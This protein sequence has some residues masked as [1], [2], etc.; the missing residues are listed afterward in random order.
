[1]NKNYKMIKI[2]IIF[3]LIDLGSLIKTAFQVKL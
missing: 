3:R 1:M 2:K